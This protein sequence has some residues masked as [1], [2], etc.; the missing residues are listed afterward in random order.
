MKSIVSCALFWMTAVLCMGGA[1]AAP[2]Y[3]VTV[4]GSVGSAAY[5]INSAGQVVGQFTTGTSLHAFYFDGTAL[6]D[7][8]TTSSG[9]S[10]ALGINDN[11]TVV[12]NF[13]LA[14]NGTQG[15]VYSGGVLSAL[16][17]NISEARG[18]NNDGTIVGSAGFLDGAGFNVRR[19]VTYAGGVL[20]N[21]GLLPGNDGE[22][23]DGYGINNAGIAVGAVEVGGAPNRPTDPFIYSG[24]VMQN[25]GNIGGVFSEAR[26]I[27]ESTQVVGVLGG[28][29]L[30][31][32]NLYPAKAFV[33]HAG[34]LQTLGELAPNGNSI[35]YDINNGGQI[36]GSAVTADGERAF[37]YA[38]AAMVA[39]DTLIDP[40]AG[41]TITAAS[42]INDA[43]Q[44]A[45]TACNLAG[46]FAVRLDLAPVPEPGHIAML[47]LGLLTLCMPA[48]R[49]HAGSY[50]T[51]VNKARRL[52]VLPDTM[53]TPSPV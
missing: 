45:A 40:M 2:T 25:L 9:N 11:G 17:A 49:R 41:W 13:G 14:D 7:I 23:S 12:G 50:D 53:K 43:Q 35:A 30:D 4:L 42:G 38:G 44:I 16:P 18:I 26:A 15:F 37:L 31:D 19:A 29:Y 39:L 28:P 10:V 21:L 8:G 3:Q 27:N 36:V 32:G 22:G 51:F 46:C 34:V 24:G 48:L 20:N 1:Q 52:I 5:G 47:G 33:W 6:N